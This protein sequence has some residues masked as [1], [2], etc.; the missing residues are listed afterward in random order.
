MKTLKRNSCGLIQFRSLNENVFVERNVDISC[1]NWNK[2][3]CT[4]RACEK[5][6]RLKLVEE[7][8]YS[9]MILWLIIDLYR[10]GHEKVAR[11]PFCTCPCD[12]LCR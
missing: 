2:K 9:P 3:R 11:V 7:M 6:V 12:I 10:M 8:N 1:D 5:K 4:G